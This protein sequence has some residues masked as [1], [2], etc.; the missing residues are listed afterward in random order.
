MPC[1]I[2]LL[3]NKK[4]W[5]VFD[6]VDSKKKKKKKRPTEGQVWAFIECWADFKKSGKKKKK[7]K[8]KKERHSERRV[9]SMCHVQDRSGIST[10]VKYMAAIVENPRLMDG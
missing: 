4:L 6:M 7:K 9:Q 8:K 1:A 10:I 3:H 2:W 5:N